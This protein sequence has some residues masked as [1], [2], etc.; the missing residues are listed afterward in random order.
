MPALQNA[1]SQILAFVAL[2]VGLFNPAQP[3]TIDEA[4]KML[5]PLSVQAM[6]EKEY[7]GSSIVIEKILS[8][9]ED[10]YRYITSYQ[11]DG[12]K[13]FAL[14]LVPKGNKP[15]NGWPVIIL[16]HGYIIPKKYTPEG[17]YIAYYDYLAKHGYIVFKPNYRGNG[18]SEGQPTS[19]YFSP[20]YVTDDLNAL[21]AI[22]KYP[23]AN[24]E[25]IG[26]WGHSMGGNITLKDIVVNT[27]DIKA[28][29]IWAGVVGNLNDIIFNWQNRVTYQ[30]DQEDLF[31]RNLNKDT[32]ISLYQTPTENPDFWNQLDPTFFLK[33]IKAPVQIQVGLA[34]SQVPPDFSKSLFEKLVKEGK[35]VEYFEYQGANHDINQSF[36]TAMK[37]TVDFF[38]LY[39]K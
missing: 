36:T 9:T 13:N 3:K 23:E 28:A 20:D 30:P 10:Y 26:V 14:L 32:L 4:N 29:S 6:R 15:T 12:L 2:L 5:N 21:A 7:P 16:N 35:K 18:K 38:D 31:L 27:S 11:S 19:T 24:P 39:L 25:R 33:D 22:K 37:R 34:D 8:S 17:N 1:V